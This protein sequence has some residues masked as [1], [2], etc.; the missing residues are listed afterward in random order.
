MQDKA[1]QLGLS[2]GKYE[3]QAHLKAIEYLYERKKL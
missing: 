1:E 3:H 2:D